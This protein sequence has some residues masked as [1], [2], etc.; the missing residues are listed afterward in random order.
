MLPEHERRALRAIEAE[1]RASDP[2]FADALSGT[3][4]AHAARWR[5]ILVLADVT[6]VLMVVFGIF[7][8]AGW[9]TFWGIVATAVLVRIHLVR[10]RRLEK[11]E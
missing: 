10:R 3:R 8:Q 7:G 6:A 11:V 4:L 1:L 9:T 5:A 2:F